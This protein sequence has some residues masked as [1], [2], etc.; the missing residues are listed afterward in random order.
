[1]ADTAASNHPHT[2][3][4]LREV[5]VR[6]I[7]ADERARWDTL[8]RAHH[9]LGFKALVGKALR[10][11]AVYRGQWLALL[12]W[13]AAALK[14]RVREEWLGWTPILHYRRLHLLA[15]N[16]RFLLLPGPR[17]ANLASRVLGLN[18]KRLSADWQRVYGHPVV[19]A[20]TFVDPSRFAGTCYR[21]ANWHPLGLTRGFARRSGRYVAHGQ[22][23][24]VWVYPLHRHARHWLSC[25][26]PPSRWRTPMQS[27]T[28]TTAQMETLQE[29]LRTLPD[30]RKARGKR[31]RLSTLLT[32]ATAAVLSGAR[33]YTAIAEWAGRL[34]QPQ[35]R[36]LRARY[37]PSTQR[38]KAP[39]EPTLRRML[40][41][42]DVEALEY[43]IGQWLF[44]VVPE[45]DAVAVDGK[46]VRGASRGQD[47][48][49]HLISAF[50][51]QQGATVASRQVGAKTN[52]IS[53]LG[54]LLEPLELTER[55]VTADAMHTQHETA[56]FLVE[57]KRAHYVFTVKGNQG[58]LFDA[59]ADLNPAF[60][61]PQR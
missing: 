39:S 31:H 8:M 29:R 27:V 30:M 24:Q 53:E 55:V 7:V 17:V 60:F 43:T 13:Q 40:Q 36:R 33:G 47:R 35:L 26:T 58:A 49:V 5:E 2:A 16:A 14:C 42:I 61:S 54:P 44:E 15:N 3:L 22:P 18:L 32:I 6:P 48:R 21:A 51:H 4:R 57:D 28:L 20:E 41:H 50:L 59:I 11:V 25:P 56:R 46:R 34:T 12:G 52:E 23:K 19:L 38:F 9:Y 37:S 45:A 10:Y 1:M